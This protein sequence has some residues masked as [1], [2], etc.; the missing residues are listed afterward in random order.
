M[1][2][3]STTSGTVVGQVTDAQGKAIVNAVVTLTN[4]A[5]NGT[6]T[7][8]SNAQGRYAFANLQAGGY[9][10]SV[11]AT[12]FKEATVKNQ[13]VVVG[14]QLTLNVPMQVGSATQTVEVT[15]SG[16]E[17]QTMNS[18]VGATISG[19]AIVMLPNIGRDANA[20]TQL[21]PNTAP[22]GAV[23]G[24]A[25]DENSYTLDGGS[26][27]DDMDGAH[28]VYN[29]SRG[30]PNSG[31]IPT[32][33]ESIEQFTVGVD[34]QTADVNAAAGSSVAMVTKRGTNA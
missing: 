33:A 30:A 6:Q 29:A 10:L 21:Q 27:S 22:N 28:T 17:L 1:L 12:G 2:A 32:P 19:D 18:T 5:N 4:S 3:Q 8:I 13:L 7:T 14:K 15:A 16:A 25:I 26:N 23:A 24:A 31:V 20:L 11:K 9:G 34:N